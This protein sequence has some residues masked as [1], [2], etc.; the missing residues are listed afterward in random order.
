M[1]F[2]DNQI[3][4]LDSILKLLKPGIRILVPLIVLC[5]ASCES[6]KA[7]ITETETKTTP[8]SNS[9][10]PLPESLP[11][12]KGVEFGEPEDPP[13]AAKYV[14]HKPDT[15]TFSNDIA[16]IVFKK[17]AICH[18]EK[19]VAPFALVS[20]DDYAKR[21]KQIVMVL[22]SAFMPP[23]P[24][25]PGYVEYKRDKSLSVNQIGII[26]QWVEE[27][28]KKGDLTKLPPVPIKKEGWELGEPDL[29]ATMKA[30]YL[31][32]ADG[33][34]EFRKV[35]VTIP[36]KETKY[37]RAFEY[38]PVNRK[39]VHHALM[40]LDRSG[41]SRHLDKITPGE[42]FDGMESG[43]EYTPEG[44]MP[45]W[46]AGYSVLE[47]EEGSAWELPMGADFIV[48]MHLLRTGKIESIQSKFGF[49]FTDERPE[50]LSTNVKLT[51]MTIDIPPNKKNHLIED[52]FVMPVDGSIMSVYPH[53]H[54]LGSDLKVFAVLPNGKKEWI[55]RIKK[56]DVNWQDIYFLEKPLAVPKGTVLVM[57]Y[58]YDNTS[59]NVFNPNDPPIRIRYGKN[60]EDEMGDAV[61]QILTKNIQDKEI[62]SKAYFKLNNVKVIEK[63]ISDIK[64]NPD[65]IEAHFL[66]GYYYSK[67]NKFDLA[68]KHYRKCISLKEDY[69]RVRNNLASI[70]IKQRK[71]LEAKKQYEEAIRQDPEDVK[72]H[73]NLGI[74]MANLN[75]NS[76]ARKLF[77]KALAIN[78]DFAEAHCNLGHILVRQ[79]KYKEAVAQYQR[80]IELKPTYVVAKHSLKKAQQMMILLEPKSN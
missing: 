38:K 62:L 13:P 79:K 41:W 15:I 53:A 52:N 37:V 44:F 21:G 7:P 50:L 17:C 48:E 56:W 42:G 57:R 9:A 54:Y 63:C 51:S 33:K 35:V 45:A 36:I 80:A 67:T 24:P 78:P 75:E 77:Q 49:Y 46:T 40:R 59:D 8:L 68:V 3:K 47:G 2:F 27:G 55:V 12:I 73:N 6:Q 19:E 18:Q 20:Y 74:L 32:D 25:T 26:K 29:I 61:L 10:Q 76:E 31:L 34:D 14:K 65:D 1:T 64:F 28:F 16:P 69:P 71:H 43:E 11:I 70:L 22:E 39:I 23:F 60:A 66:I 30:P 4:N 72:A 5:L 58:I